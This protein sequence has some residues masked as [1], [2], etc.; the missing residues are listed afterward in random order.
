MSR[1]QPEGRIKD[2]CRTDHADPNG[3]IFWQIEGK[4]RNG[5]PDTLASR[6]A[7]GAVLI[8]FKK[9]GERPTEQQYL[10]IHEL[11][12]EGIEAWWTD[13]VEGYRKIVGLD[14]GGYKVEYPE[15]ILRLIALA[16]KADDL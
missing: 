13:S 4:S 5:I 1:R 15:K 12:A 3:L 7:G 14:P 16:T 6:C 8:E 10:R 11:R 2:H 9:P